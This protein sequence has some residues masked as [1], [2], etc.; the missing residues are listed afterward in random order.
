MASCKELQ[1]GEICIVEHYRKVNLEFPENVL[2]WEYIG[3]KMTNKYAFRWKHLLDDK[4]FI[5]YLT[6]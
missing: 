4:T 1:R 6:Q 2:G 3:Y 5:A